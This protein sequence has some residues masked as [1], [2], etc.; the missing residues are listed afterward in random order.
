MRMTRRMIGARTVSRCTRFF[1]GMVHKLRWLAS[2]DMFAKMKPQSV[3]RLVLLSL[4]FL[5][6]PPLVLQAQVPSAELRTV[7]AVRGL[8]VEQ[9]AQKIPVQLHGVVTFFDENLF[10]RFI[11]DETAGIYL[12]FPTNVGPPMLVPGQVVEVT[13]FGSPGSTHRW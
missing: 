3:L 12:Q 11:Q 8:S 7:A 6:F 10:S 13:G 2:F 9:T 5:P 4:F 1:G